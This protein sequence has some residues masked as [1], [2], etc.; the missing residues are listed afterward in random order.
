L[1]RKKIKFSFITRKGFVRY[2]T[3]I[4]DV[5]DEPVEELE[6]VIAEDD[7]IHNAEKTTIIFRH[8]IFFEIILKPPPPLNAKKP[9]I[10]PCNVYY[11]LILPRVRITCDESHG[12]SKSWNNSDVASAHGQYTLGRPPF[13]PIFYSIYI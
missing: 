11:Y 13:C 2:L 5:E 3:N 7:V 10:T 9:S 6:D 12:I 4:N 1:L 8:I